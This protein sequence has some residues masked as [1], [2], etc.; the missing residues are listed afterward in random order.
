MII[1]WD[2]GLRYKKCKDA[3]AAQA[4]WIC[5]QGYTAGYALKN[6]TAGEAVM[7]KTGDNMSVSEGSHKY[8][9]QPGHVTESLCLSLEN[10]QDKD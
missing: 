6:E 4:R 2:V 1:Y 3:V 10:T 8:W 5:Q 9:G 7:L